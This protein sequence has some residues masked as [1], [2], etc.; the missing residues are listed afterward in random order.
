MRKIKDRIV[1]KLWKIRLKFFEIFKFR[2]V[3]SFYGIKLISNYKDI[4]FNFYVTGWY[5]L[6]YYKHLSCQKE[7][8]VFL[9][10]GANQGLY[11]ICSSLNKK[12]IS[13]YS[14]EPVKKTFDLL[15][16]NVHINNVD[17]KCILINKAISDIAGKSEIK[18]SMNHSGA[19]TMNDQNLLTD[20]VNIISEKIETITSKDLNKILK[21]IKCKII[22]KIDVEG[23]E[24][25]VIVELFKSEISSLISEIF[26]EVDERWEC[27]NDIKILLEENGFNNLKKENIINGYHYDVYATRK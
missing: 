8:F 20:E 24:K 23:L 21:D 16:K 1:Y 7:P 5:G 22:V 11:T 6:K 2:I 26:F 13:C 19:A 17:S 18:I 4:T 12:C 14:F 25:K 27:Y 3:K 9:D 10:I 15:S